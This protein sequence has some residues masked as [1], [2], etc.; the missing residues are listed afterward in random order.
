MQVGQT[1]QYV[2]VKG[3]PDRR[4]KNN[5]V[6]PIMRY[7]T[8]EFA[9]GHGLQWQL[10]VSRADAAA[11]V[12][13]AVI[14]VPALTQTRHA[15]AGG[16]APIRAQ[17]SQSQSPTATRSD[18]A[19]TTDCRSAAH[20]IGFTTSPRFRVRPSRPH[21]QPDTASRQCCHLYRD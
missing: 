10:Q 5:R 9:S 19:T 14:T 13:H 16:F 21:S 11:P 12:A 4:Y 17:T 18:T 3:G 6:L 15:A 1:W 8:L 20:A 7:G 2:N